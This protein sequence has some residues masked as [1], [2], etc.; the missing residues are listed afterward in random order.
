[1]LDVPPDTTAPSPPPTL[2]VTSLSPTRLSLAWPMPIDNVSQVWTTLLVNG[3]PYFTDQLGPPSA[4]VGNLTP[5]T[6]YALQATVRD[7]FGNVAEGEVLT[8]ITP[9]IT[10]TQAPTAPANVRVLSSSYP[11]DIVLGW[12]QSTDNS[13][14]Q[15]Q[16]RYEVFL[17]GVSGGS[18]IGVGRSFFSCPAVGPTEIVMKAFDTSGNRSGPS[19]TPTF[20]CTGA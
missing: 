19:N 17:N 11:P 4:I 10:D 6:T 5:A 13:D 14:L 9:A 3:S 16:I 15:A 7:A 8:V 12:D 18:V 20:D 1:L 2:S